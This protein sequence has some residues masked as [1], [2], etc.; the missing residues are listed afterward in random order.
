MKTEI[1]SNL[2][3][4]RWNE[5]INRSINGTLFHTWEWLKIVELHSESK[6][7]PLVFF[8]ADDNTPFGAIPLF[9][10]KRF[11]LKMIFSPPPG[12]AITLGPVL[13]NKGYKQHKFELSYL[14]FQS[15][16][17]N[18]IKNKG[19][20]FTLML[21]SPGIIDIRPFSWS[22]YSATPGYT[23]KID[24][25]Q[26]EEILWNNLRKNTRRDISI[27]QKKGIVIEEQSNKAALEFVYSSSVAR[28]ARSRQRWAV[29][30]SYVIDLYD[31]FSQNSIKI[32]A[33][34]Y[35]GKIVTALAC[36]IFKDTVVAWMGGAKNDISALEA[37]KLLYWDIIAKAANNRYKYFEL[38]GANTR[39]LCEFKSM[40][41]PQVDILFQLKKANLLGHLAE[42]TYSSFQKIFFRR[43]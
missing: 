5:I 22:H 2:D 14:D 36:T 21:T 23:Y 28:Y 39:H 32:Y 25:S 33:S 12:T 8:D 31:Q 34:L 9:Y 11:G 16:I 13:I 24:L 40:F 29:E 42:K 43:K 27:A 18:F 35:Q 10:I 37:N 7:F 19:S 6:L 17:D 15:N 3:S 20:N 1:F 4:T 38:M 41:G 26:G 30:K